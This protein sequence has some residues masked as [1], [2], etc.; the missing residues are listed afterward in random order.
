MN[1]SVVLPNY[2]G[3]VILR[4]NLPKLIEAIKNYKDSIREVIITDDCS[5]DGSIKAIKEFAKAYENKG[6]EINL[7]SSSVNSGFSSNVNK[8]FAKARGEIVI[9]LNTDVVPSGDFLTPILRH[10]SDE[11]VFGV[12]CMNESVE[13]GK[14]VLRGRGIGQWKRGFLMHSGGALDKNNTLWVSGGSSAFRKKIWDELG[15]LD[16]IYNPFYWE[17]IDI[18]YVAQRSGYKCIFEKSSVVRHEHEKGA[19]K[20]KYSPEEIKKIAYRNQFIFVWKNAEGRVLLNHVFWLP[21]HLATGIL[22]DR[23]LIAGFLKAILI[24]HKVLNSRRKARKHFKLSDRQIM[25]AYKT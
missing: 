12:G 10:F 25:Q 19:I 15:G 1:I 4:K 14:I 2:N 24:I 3:E 17:D 11:K 13:N 9:L 21:Y 8:G 7:L 6:V 18:S 23:A 16:E 20:I 22:G 5:T